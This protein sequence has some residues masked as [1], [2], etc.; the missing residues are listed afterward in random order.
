MP[1]RMTLTVAVPPTCMNGAK[2]VSFNIM[3]AAQSSGKFIRIVYII[4]LIN[5]INLYISS[6]KSLCK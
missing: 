1:V 3:E 5:K 4:K 2:K 6:L